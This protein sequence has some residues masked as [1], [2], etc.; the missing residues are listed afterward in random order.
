MH[1]SHYYYYYKHWSF[2]RG[3]TKP[4]LQ[5]Y[6]NRTSASSMAAYKST[7]KV[8]VSIMTVAGPFRGGGRKIFNF[9]KVF[10]TSQKCV[11]LYIGSENV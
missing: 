3:L 1:R 7:Q 4:R 5:I 11:A 9:S 10:I 8:S 2:A 6:K